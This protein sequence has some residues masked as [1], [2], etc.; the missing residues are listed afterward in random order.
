MHIS[1]IGP[2]SREES[3]RRVMKA[4]DWLRTYSPTQNHFTTCKARARERH[5]LLLAGPN[6]R[7]R[8]RHCP[9]QR[10]VCPRQRRHLHRALLFLNRVRST[11]YLPHTKALPFPHSPMA[12]ATITTNPQPLTTTSHSRQN[13]LNHARSFSS[14]SGAYEDQDS[15]ITR[16]NPQMSFSMSQG[17]QGSSLMM[18]PGG[19]FR[20]YE[21]NNGV[22]RRNSAPQIYSV[23]T[24][25]TFVTDPC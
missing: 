24:F 9:G 1:C 5:V 17:S 20:Q 3:G 23:R 13:H 10:R 11:R 22:N 4:N 25:L 7:L 15:P 16:S 21:G 8:Y 6:Q 19:P 18:Q 2:S 14:A 12:S